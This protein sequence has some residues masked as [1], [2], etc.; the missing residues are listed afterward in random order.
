[1][2]RK[3]LRPM[4][5]AAILA[6]LCLSTLSQIPAKAADVVNLRIFVGLGTGTDDEQRT[7][8]DALAKEW[9]DAHPAIQI[10]FEYNDYATA[11]D[12]LLT[13]IAGDHSPDIVGP[14]GIGGLN[15]T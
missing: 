4:V 14:V 6:A 8:Q 5:A 1:M 11:R 3:L 12:V 10:K 15:S 2:S 13:Q 7:A 9:N